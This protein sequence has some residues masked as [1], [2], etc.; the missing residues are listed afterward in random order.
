[1]GITLLPM[2][3][4]CL[5]TYCIAPNSAPA[6]TCNHTIQWAAIRDDENLIATTQSIISLYSYFSGITK[7][8]Y[9]SGQG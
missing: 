2:H 4:C 9:G 7:I 3:N 8:K 6:I 5:P 1:M